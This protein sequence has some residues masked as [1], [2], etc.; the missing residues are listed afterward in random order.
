MQDDR[1]QFYNFA[2]AHA[3]PSTIK[4]KDIWTKLNNELINVIDYQ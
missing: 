4:L 3:A 2:R 1:C